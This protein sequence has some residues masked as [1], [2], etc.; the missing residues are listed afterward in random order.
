MLSGRQRETRGGETGGERRGDA[1]SSQREK[2][3]VASA[4]RDARARQ[5]LQH[6][7]KRGKHI[8]YENN[9]AIS[10]PVMGAH[11]T[12]RRVPLRAEPVL[13]RPVPAAAPRSAWVSCHTE[14]RQAEAHTF[15]RSMALMAMRAMR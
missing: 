15:P 6:D 8:V 12:C 14:D 11:M 9:T 2:K 7:K 4:K 13:P 1:R 5:H 3:N 10:C